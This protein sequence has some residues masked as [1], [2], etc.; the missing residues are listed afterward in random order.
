M[1]NELEFWLDALKDARK[2]YIMARAAYVTVFEG[3]MERKK[4]NIIE[5]IKGKTFNIKDKGKDKGNL[6]P[7]F[8]EI[9]YF[10]EYFDQE[11]FARLTIHFVRDMSDVEQL[12]NLT[13]RE[14]ALVKKFTDIYHKLSMFSFTENKEVVEALFKIQ[15]DI[16]YLKNNITLYDDPSWYYPSDKIFDEDFIEGGLKYSGT[17]IMSYGEYRSNNKK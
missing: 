10:D 9:R 3:L 15:R 14:S 11:P 17:S 5:A 13:A 4:N 2:Q 7:I 6:R 12:Q 1:T 8:V 16:D